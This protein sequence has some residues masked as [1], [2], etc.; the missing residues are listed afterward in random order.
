MPVRIRF[1]GPATLNATL[2]VSWAGGYPPGATATATETFKGTRVSPWQT[3]IGSDAATQAQNYYNAMLLDFSVNFTI[4]KIGNDVIINPKNGTLQVTA[5]TTSSNVII[6]PSI[7]QVS[8]LGS[9]QELTPAY[10][11]VTFQFFSAYYSQPGH[12]Y[13]VGV[14]KNELDG[15]QSTIGNYKI[16]PQIDGTGYIDISKCLTNFLTVDYNQ[17]SSYTLDCSN[18]YVD[19]TIGIG[20]E[21][22]TNWQYANYS[23]YGVTGPNQGLAL[24]T[25]SPTIQAHTYGTGDQISITTTD[26]VISGLHTVKAIVSPYKIVIDTPYTGATVSTAGITSYADGRKTAYNNVITQRG[27][28]FNG[29]RSWTEFP[30]WSWEHWLIQ[31]GIYQS[32]DCELLTS[33]RINSETYYNTDDHFYMTPEQAIWLNFAVD[34]PNKEWSVEWD[35]SSEDGAWTYESGSFVIDDGTNINGYVKQFRINP[36][37]L[38]G[39]SSN[40]DLIDKITFRVKDDVGEAV[41][42]FYAVYLDKRCRIEKY[43]LYFMDRMGSILSF[44]CQLRAKET[45][46]ITR[47][48]Y[49]QQ[50]YY[51]EQPSTYTTPVY[52]TTDRGTNINSVNVVKELELNTNWMNNEMSLLFEELLTSPYVWLHTVLEP[53][54][55]LPE[56][57]V[58]TAVTVNESSFEVQTQKNKRLIRKTVTVKQ[59][60]ENIINI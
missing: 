48:T 16:T 11:P 15:S 50:V 12:R 34:N 28:V 3:T 47:E 29:A 53:T 56:R 41:T 22:Q 7:S 2:T 17:S 10:N 35:A 42:R 24:L 26:T 52:Q 19:Y 59:A 46:T 32:P 51:N 20:E 44:A 49:K 57:N 30:N 1:T 9:P 43:D 55:E 40:Y 25:Q 31:Y 13:L 5:S 36:N 37:E 33:L 14:Y 18:S 8:L 54:N 23:S 27:F 60:N 45:G 38:I 39:F 58:Y 21:F 4:T 6:N